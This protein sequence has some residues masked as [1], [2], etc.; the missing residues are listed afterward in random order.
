MSEGPVSNPMATAQRK[1]RQEL[2]KR[3]YSAVAVGSVEGGYGILLDGRPV[4]TPAK[5]LLAVPVRR[6]AEAIAAEWAAQGELIQPATM[7]LTRIVNAAIDR[8]SGEMDAVRTDVVA[9]AASDLICY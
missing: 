5:K 1:A 3:F 9:H 7:P 4:R 2:P 6:V 8:V